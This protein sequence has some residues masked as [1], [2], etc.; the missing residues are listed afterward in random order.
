LIGVEPEIIK[1]APA[2]RI[3]VL[4]LRKRLTAPSYGTT[5]GDTP[6]LA[7]VTLVV[8]GAVVC[9]AGFLRRRMKSDIAYGDTGLNRHAEGLDRSIE[10]LVIQR[11]LV[12]PDPY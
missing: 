4:V 6:R 12:V 2:N 8:K 7:A 1:C 9:P 10:V 11:I 3:R 5:R